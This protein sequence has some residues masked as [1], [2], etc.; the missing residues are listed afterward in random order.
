MAC[1]DTT[2][3]IDMA[4]RNARLRNRAFTKLKEL[5]R[6]DEIL[7]ITRFNLA[8]L[9]VG[10]ARSDNPR[11]EEKAVQ[12]LVADFDILEFDDKAAWLFG[13]ITAH[14]IDLGQP[15]GDMD[16]LIAATVM[17]AGHTLITRNIAH[18]ANIP[19]LAAEGY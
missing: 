18:F 14:L 3:L 2:M 6:R 11:A 9:Y 8:E 5:V 1:L 17:A 13:R 4:G 12:T 10:V 15:A 7:V 19:E 16:V